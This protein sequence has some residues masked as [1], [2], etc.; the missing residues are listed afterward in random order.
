M[1]QA[2][3][4]QL[5]SYPIKSCAGIEYQIIQ[6]NALGLAGDRQWMLVDDNGV[7]LSQRKHPCMAL[8]QPQIQD[9][10]LIVNAPG[11]N[12]LVLDVQ[13]V[14]EPVE[15]KV[16]QDS[17]L[18]Q[19]LGETANQW[20]S[21]YLGF[22]VRLV[23]Y[24]NVSHRLIDQEFAQRQQPVAFADAYPILVT[25]ESTLSQLN[26]QLS[27]PVDMS[28]FRPNIVVSTQQPAWDE[29]NWQQL[30]TT[31]LQLDLVKPC[32]RCVMTGVEQTS[33]QQTGAEVLKTLS[34]KFAHQG[35][36]VFGVNAIPQL[37]TGAGTKL[38]VGA[39]L[40]ICQNPH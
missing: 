9:N 1:T 11:M 18:A 21:K 27:Q 30:Q 16:W 32:S 15:I 17:F 10:N 29:L 8:I 19:T 22:T 7:F 3:I 38:A 12:Q 5:I 2:I 33:G 34:Q 37:K 39:Q 6:V 26:Q 23:Q 24:T 4:T 20:F 14:Q 25:H 28:R 13:S 36:A 31:D 40:T 35:K